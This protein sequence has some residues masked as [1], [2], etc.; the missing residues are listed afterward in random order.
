MKQLK[1]VFVILFNVTVFAGCI[2]SFISN[3]SPELIEDYSVIREHLINETKSK[4]VDLIAVVET[5]SDHEIKSADLRIDLIKPQ[6]FSN[7]N[8]DNN[9][10]AKE[11]AR[12]VKRKLKKPEQYNLI[13]INEITEPTN[14]TPAPNISNTIKLQSKDL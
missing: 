2:Q 7:L 4:S 10:K 3:G 5:N 14:T 8:S 9:A 1:L 12:W 13:I 6:F 11:L